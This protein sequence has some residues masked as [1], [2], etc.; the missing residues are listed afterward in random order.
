MTA[1]A[2]HSDG[3]RIRASGVDIAFMRTVGTIAGCVV[4]ACAARNGEGYGIL[5]AAP[6][7]FLSWQAPGSATA[8]TPTQATADGTYLLEDGEDASKWISVTVSIDYL[9]SAAQGRVYIADSFNAIGI[10]DV[11]AA[12][13]SA[14]LVSNATLTLYNAT[15]F[16]VTNIKLWLE[17][18][19]GLEVSSDNVTFYAPTSEADSHVITYA[20]LA[21]GASVNL[22]VRRTISPS[23][24]SN[25]AILN[26]IVYTW[27]GV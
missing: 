24:A 7:G 20:S 15:G 18:I 22:Y 23:T 11:A 25:A 6:G 13:A 3:L 21:A 8:G 10:A 14:G 9:P 2:T 16:S 19:T 5:T 17:D 1:P 26:H 27:T 12:D 4:A